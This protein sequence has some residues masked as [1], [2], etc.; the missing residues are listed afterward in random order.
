[1]YNI[2][3]GSKTNGPRVATSKVQEKYLKSKKSQFMGFYPNTESCV[4]LKLMTCKPGRM[5]MGNLLCGILRRD[6]E[7]HYTF[8]EMLLP[9]TWKRNPHIFIGRYITVTQRDDKSLR[10]NFRPLMM[11]D[12]FSVD[13]YTL[14]VYNELRKALEGLVEKE[15]TR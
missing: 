15:A 13:L 11:D 6:G 2:K 12:T 7:E 8:V 5:G 14:G 1:M 9:K 4:D 3:P 10:L